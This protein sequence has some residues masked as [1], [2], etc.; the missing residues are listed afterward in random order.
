MTRSQVG[1][2]TRDEVT[3]FHC[4]P[5]K[6]LHGFSTMHVPLFFQVHKQLGAARACRVIAYVSA[7]NP[8]RAYELF[9]Q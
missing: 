1:E 4:A 3:R 5:Q 2:T 6:L 9:L 8:Q 7:D